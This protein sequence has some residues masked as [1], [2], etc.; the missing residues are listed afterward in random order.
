MTFPL[1]LPAPPH[2][3]PRKAPALRW[4]ILGPGII[5]ADL[6]AALLAHTG[7]EVVAVGSRSRDRARS[8]A[9][10]FGIDRAY[11]SYEELVADPGVDA[12]YVA[13]PMSEHYAQTLLCIEAGKPTL[14]EKSFT[15]TAAEAREVQRRAVE[16]GVFVMEAMKTRYLPQM[17]IIDQLLG[18]GVLG[19][20][21][22]VVAQYGVVTPYQPQHRLFDPILGGGVLLDIGVY[23]LSLAFT[24]L[25]EF[26][27][28]HA[29]GTLAPSGVE[30]AVSALLTTSTGSRALINASWRGE[31]PVRADIGGSLNRVELG[32]S[33]QNPA[34]LSLV[35]PDRR[36]RLEWDDQRFPG[37]AGMVFQV[38]AMA[39]YLEAGLTESPLHSLSDSVAVMALLDE[40]RHQ[41]GSQFDDERQR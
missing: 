17:Q 12:I 2:I 19:T 30:D 5:A 9:E 16:A 21:D 28:A 22:S 27:S 24:L 40:L 39:R 25:G 1:A 32:E 11:G 38:A 3:D 29:S 14:V 31:A 7:Q 10:R 37:R 6:V 35:S 4:G 18:D 36:R 20:I 34:P 33:F 23:P 13:T 26:S 41:V 8:F 15:R